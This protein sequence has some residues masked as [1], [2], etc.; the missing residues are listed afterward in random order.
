M[1]TQPR[2]FISYSRADVLFAKELANALNQ[3]KYKIFID[4]SD[5]EAGDIF[6][7]RILN[8]IQN[9]DGV[10]SLISQT[11]VTSEWC[12]LENFYAHFLKKIIIPIKL[13]SNA[14]NDNSPLNH[15]QKD[16]NYTI[17][18]QNEDVESVVFRIEKKLK[19][20]ARH[21]Y[22]RIIK[23]VLILT[24]IAAIIAFTIVFGVT[25]INT[26]N[27]NQSKNELV[28][29]I[30]SSTLVYTTAELTEIKKKYAGDQSLINILQSLSKNKAATV[31]GKINSLILSGILDI[32]KKVL[33]PTNLEKF[34]WENSHI[35]NSSLY[36][37]N[38]AQGVIRKVEINQCDLT[39][40]YFQGNE[41]IQTSLKMDD[42]SFNNCIIT[43]AFFNKA[44]LTNVNFTDTRFSNTLFNATNFLDVTFSTTIDTSTTYKIAAGT[45]FY[46]CVFECDPPEVK[47]SIDLVD[48]LRMN[49]SKVIFDG[50]TFKEN[51]NPVWFQ[52][53]GFFNCRFASDELKNALTRNNN[54]IH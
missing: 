16:I 33:Q 37:L 23:S 39:K 11:S 30:K 27:Y 51:I 19:S 40:V 5:I 50:C 9:S 42:I 15:F 13:T 54:V 34:E 2:L 7:Q 36:N 31:S 1:I 25:K 24:G 45:F 29:S 12:K 20:V 4:Q 32:Q 43:N 3:K 47:V 41:T 28:K 44:Y 6:P 53:C 8:G 14:V 46:E 52:D 10:I 22:N 48:E 49:F 21:R 26:F 38:F 18:N 17:V 35:D